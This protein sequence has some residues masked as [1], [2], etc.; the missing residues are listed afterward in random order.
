MM[1]VTHEMSFARNVSSRVFY[2][3]EKGIYED[4]T[5]QQ[6]FEAPQKV[7]TREFIYKTHTYSQTIDRREFD[8]YALWADVETFLKSQSLPEKRIHASLLLCEE[9]LYR[10]VLDRLGD[11]VER[12]EF[13]LEYSETQDIVGL[14]FAAPQITCALKEQPADPLAMDIVK[15]Y[16]REL[17]YEEGRLYAEV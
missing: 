7:K 15:G 3:D 13:K 10:L 11:T 14:S 17:R 2:M 6:I 5:P 4:G 1:I 12:L 9:L 8:P 16:A